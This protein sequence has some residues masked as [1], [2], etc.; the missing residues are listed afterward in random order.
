MRGPGYTAA[1][2]QTLAMAR[3]MSAAKKHLA[4]VAALGC[5]ICGAPAEIHHPRFVC[6][7][8]QRAPDWLAVPL[9]PIHHRTGGFGVAIHAGQQEFERNYMSEQDLLAETIRRI[10]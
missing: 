8:S 1:C 2:A 3:D 6:G 9:C 4:R 10:A 5:I 7:M